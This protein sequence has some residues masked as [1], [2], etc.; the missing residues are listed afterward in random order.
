MKI[1]ISIIIIVFVLFC[2]YTGFL[3]TEVAQLKEEIIN[4]ELDNGIMKIAQKDCNSK[5][6]S[7]EEDL[8]IETLVVNYT[9]NEIGK[10]VS[11]IEFMQML[12]EVNN[13]IYP[14]YVEEEWK[15]KETVKTVSVIIGI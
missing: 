14:Y 5:I 12:C 7:L 10:L 15:W 6:E 13:I 4:L 2:F 9:K 3:R 11:Y 1:F 8:A